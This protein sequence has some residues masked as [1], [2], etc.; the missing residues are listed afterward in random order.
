MKVAARG[1][2]RMGNVRAP[3]AFRAGCIA[4]A[5]ISVFNAQAGYTRQKDLFS[6][7][8]V[9]FADKGLL[10][11]TILPVVVVCVCLARNFAGVWSG[12]HA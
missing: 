5:S 2:L 8:G 7:L 11:P 1:R 9:A 4:V 10:N 3:G 12:T 6:T